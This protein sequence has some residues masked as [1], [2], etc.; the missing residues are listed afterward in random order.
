MSNG[1]RVGPRK[2]VCVTSLGLHVCVGAAYVCIC[3]CIHQYIATAI[4]IAVANRDQYY[5][6]SYYY[7]NINGSA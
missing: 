6:H 4:T 3:V 5:R 2:A 1:A 7:H